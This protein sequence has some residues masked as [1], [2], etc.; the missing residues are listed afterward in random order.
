[1]YA[2]GS[3]ILVKDFTCKKREEGNLDFL[4]F[5]LNSTSL[6]W[7]LRKR[8][9][10]LQ[11]EFTLEKKVNGAYIKPYIACGI[12]EKKNLRARLSQLQEKELHI[13]AIGTTN[14]PGCSSREN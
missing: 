5:G 2:I 9:Y 13:L 4:W 12:E 6:M 3:K 10:L 8:S 7:N 11:E 1:M 14:S